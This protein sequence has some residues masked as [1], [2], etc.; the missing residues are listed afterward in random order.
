MTTLNSRLQL[1]LL[2]R[3]KSR[4]LIQ[5]GF[6]LVELMVVIVIVGILSSVAL[7]QFLK[8]GVKAQG[9]EARSDISSIIKNT[10]AEY[11]QG[12]AKYIEELAL[13]TS[14]TGTNPYTFNATTTSCDSLGG[15]AFGTTQK[16]D[17][18]CALQ[19]ESGDGSEAG[20]Y[21][22]E[23]TFS[24]DDY[25]LIVTAVGD[26]NETNLEGKTVQQAVNLDNGHTQLIKST[27]CQVF[28]GTVATG[29]TPAPGTGVAVADVTL[30]C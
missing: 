9:T 28:G 18:F 5:K 27:T 12:G 7:P 17:Y 20:T 6:T 19:Q 22:D 1:A 13:G 29:A 10:A 2:N 4:N 21:L 23:G 16:F 30:K 3:K 11:Q 8:Q 25:V 14:A 26:A 24:A 15:R